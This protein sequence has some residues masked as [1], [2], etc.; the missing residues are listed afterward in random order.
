V[1]ERDNSGS[2]SRN[3]GKDAE[4]LSWP[5]YKGKATVDGKDYW[6]SGWVKKGKDG[7]AFLSLAFKPREAKQRDEAREQ[8]PK[9]DGPLPF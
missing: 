7:G 2:L 6:V 4:H 3:E 9:L 8:E 1:S 5:D